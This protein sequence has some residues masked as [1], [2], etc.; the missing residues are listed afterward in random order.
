MKKS[1]FK[2]TK[3]QRYGI[4]LLILIIIVIQFISAFVKFPSN[5]RV[6]IPPN[7]E[8]FQKEIDSLK[9]LTLKDNKPK[10]FPFNPNFIDDY[11][12]YSIGMSSQEI[13]RLLEFRKLNKWIN[14]VSQFQRVTRVSDSLLNQ[15]SPYFKFPEWITNP[16]NRTKFKKQQVENKTFEEKIDFNLASLEQLQQIRGIGKVL[17]QRIINYRNKFDGG[18]IADIQLHDIYGIS[19]EVEERLLHEFTVKTPRKINPINL[20]SATVEQLVTVQY[21]D[22]ELAYE[23]IN[24]RTLKEGFNSFD[25]LTKV[26]DFP[27][28]K[29]DIIQLYL[30]VN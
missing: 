30:T 20:N 13:D 12:G 3:G 10:I 9:Q 1:H 21:I 6:L 2:F 19:P 22:Y 14:S 27:N 8:E 28:D 15:M 7:Y 17:S 11:K 23:I 24:Q 5:D 18:F 16:K 29:L 25:D 4:F 26:K